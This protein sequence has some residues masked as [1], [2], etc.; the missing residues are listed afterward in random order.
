VIIAEVGETDDL[1]VD[2]GHEIQTRQTKSLYTLQFLFRTVPINHEASLCVLLHL[3]TVI[4]CGF[5]FRNFMA[6]HADAL[7][8]LVFHARQRGI[9]EENV[10]VQL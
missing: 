3:T 10:Q 6:V 8:N 2:L 9:F 1:W 7:E 5:N 4:L